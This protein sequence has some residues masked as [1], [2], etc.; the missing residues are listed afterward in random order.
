M[1]ISAIGIEKGDGRIDVMASECLSMSS[2]IGKSD[3][4]LEHDI[5]GSMIAYTI[6]DIEIWQGKIT[7]Q[8][9]NQLPSMDTKDDLV[10]SKVSFLIYPRLALD[11]HFPL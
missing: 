2:L 10:M 7:L 1:S 8:L 9:P 6:T 11:F 4:A 3:A 5:R